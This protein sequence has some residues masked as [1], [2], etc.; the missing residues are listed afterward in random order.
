MSNRQI[1]EDEVSSR[2]G[3]I[4]IGHPR[5][6]DTSEN[7]CGRGSRHSSRLGDRT[8]MFQS[9]EQEEV[10]IVCERPGRHHSGQLR[11]HSIYS[12][13]RGTYTSDLSL[14][15][16]CHNRSSTTGGGST[17][18]RSACA[19]IGQSITHSFSFGIPSDAITRA[20]NKEAYIWHPFHKLSPSR[21]AATLAAGT[22]TIVHSRAGA[23]RSRP[24]RGH[25][26]YCFDSSC[27]VLFVLADKPVGYMSRGIGIF[28]SPQNEPLV[29]EGELR[30]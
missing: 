16:P 14:P 25:H 7:W 5:N 17:G 23:R 18:R 22:P 30:R 12:A 2:V 3:P 4:E 8:R 9:R 13:K 6:R 21:A 26:G 29:A 28:P 10:G 24:S 1:R 15:T 27:R 11:S 20:T 19:A